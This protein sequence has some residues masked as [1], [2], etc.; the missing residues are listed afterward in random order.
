MTT[1]QT[2]VAASVGVCTGCQLPKRL[3]ADGTIADHIT[4]RHLRADSEEREP[5]VGVG[6][7]AVADTVVDGTVVEARKPAAPRRRP[8]VPVQTRPVVSPRTGVTVG[9]EVLPVM[10]MLTPKPVVVVEPR[11]P[12]EVLE[13]EVIAN[14]TAAMR[15]DV[16][17]VKQAIEETVAETAAAARQPNRGAC[18]ICNKVVSL[19]PDG[20]ARSHRDLLQTRCEGQGRLARNAVT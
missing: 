10:P 13:P 19:D 15:A 2:L 11:R 7:A 1:S 20:R 14:L 4:P 8:V 6:L 9:E 5:C 16:A 17:A 3:D 12:F 18:R